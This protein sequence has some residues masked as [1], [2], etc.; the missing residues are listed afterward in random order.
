MTITNEPGIYVE[1]KFGIRIENLLMVVEKEKT[2]YGHFLKFE[3]L[4][5][6]PIDTRPIDFSLLTESE[7]KWLNDYHAL[8][9]TQLKP[10]LADAADQQWLEKAT[11]KI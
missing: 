7:K 8:V 9:C 1:G 11:A 3:T 4:T 2:P 5:L 10:L 6:C